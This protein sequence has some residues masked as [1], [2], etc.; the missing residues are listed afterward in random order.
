MHIGDDARAAL[1]AYVPERPE[2]PAVEA[3]DAGV[4]RMRVEII[5]QDE[6]N[7][8][9]AAGCAVTEQKRTAFAARVPASLAEL[10]AQAPP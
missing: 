8:P 6:I 3:H 1:L 7:D 2:I 10:H 4:E 9:G 5:V